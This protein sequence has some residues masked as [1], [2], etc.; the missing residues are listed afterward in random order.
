MNTTAK[1]LGELKNL[2]WRSKTIKDELRDNLIENKKSQIDIF[3]DIHGYDD[4][5]I[6]DLERA[7]LSKHDINFLGLRGQAKT[8]IARKLVEL[9]DEYIPIIE[10][11]VLNDDPYNPISFYGKDLILKKG[12]NTPISW[13]HKSTRFSEKLATPDV[14]VPD[15]IGD[16]DPIKA[17]SLKLSFSDHQVINYGLIPRSNRCIFV[18]NEIPDLQPRIQVSLFNILQENDIQIRGFNFR[19]PLDIQFIFTANPE[20]YTNRGN[21]VTPLKDRIG[22][23]ILTHYPKSVEVSKKITSQEIKVDDEIKNKIYVPNIARDL[24]EQLAFEARNYEFVDIKSG[25][26]A[27]LT[28]SA[29]EYMMATAERRMY[30]NGDENTIIRL[31]DFI[32]I[33]PAVNGKLELVYE[34][35]QEGS[36]IVVL[37]LIGK[38]I[39]SVFNKN[40]PVISEIKKDKKSENPYSSILKWFEKNKLNINNDISDKEYSDLLDSVDGLKEF[41]ENHLP[42]IDNKELKFYMEF[43]LHGIS[44]NSLISKK[45]TSTSVDFKDLISDI[46]SAE[47]KKS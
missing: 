36:Y 39:K 29:F 22:S 31:S 9:L 32:S 7:I 20:D 3:N 43:L 5:V 38:T 46:F 8:R 16:V 17:A 26:S 30:T 19:M 37:N 6:P 23:Q 35:E 47:Q 21:I 44:E 11:S 27:R 15:L 14:T 41:V 42:K 10:G 45:Y 24:I 18:I 28:I 34:G 1:T 2:N 25:V 12:D 33:I 13:I 4:T 40:F